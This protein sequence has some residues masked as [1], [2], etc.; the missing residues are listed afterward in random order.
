M[1]AGVLLEQDVQP[2]EQS[3]ELLC[4]HW[5]GLGV[6]LSLWDARGRCLQ[7][8]RAAAGPSKVLWDHSA[9]FRAW[10]AALCRRAVAHPADVARGQRAGLLGF[11]VPVVCCG[12]P[13]QVVVAVLVPKGFQGGDA[14][15]QL[16][17]PASLDPAIVTR[18]A[19]DVA[20]HD[21]RAVAGLEE[22]L[23]LLVEQLSRHETGTAPMQ[24]LAA[25]LAQ[26]YEV[27]NLIYH[28]SDKFE[29]RQEPD[30]FFER[31]FAEVMAVLQVESLAAVTHVSR[32][33][34][35]TVV[36][37]GKGLGQRERIHAVA[38][39]L[40]SLMLDRK[41]LLLDHASVER[42]LPQEQWLSNL[43]AV[44]LLHQG[45]PVGALLAI[46]KAAGKDFD[47]IDL[48]ML[49]VLADRCSLYL[50]DLQILADLQELLIALLRSLVS[51]IDAMDP[52]TS[53]HSE[54]VAF[55]TRKLAEHMHYDAALCQRAY[56]G[57][58]LHDIGK[59]TI[60]GRIL[61]K[62]AAL[63]AEEFDRI[64]QHPISGARLIGRIPAMQDVVPA[65][66]GHHE[67]VDGTGYPA[68]LAGDEL[69]VLARLVAVADC[70][71]AMTSRRAYRS[72][73]TIES[74]RQELASV[75]G[76]HLD[77][78]MVQA[79]LSMDLVQLHRELETY[80]SGLRETQREEMSTER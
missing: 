61:R 9:Q 62:P 10:L 46:N 58:L 65:V 70:F 49:Q 32:T 79:L 8:D 36:V 31:T 67:R 37:V 38:E 14:L 42:F 35:P 74:A 29:H 75:A 18:L 57:G 44:W 77:A 27:L 23:T 4:S 78:E 47:P 15:Q 41:M 56:F 11:A 1:S 51:T 2:L 17:E 25:N 76:T 12:V 21:P 28:V 7:T 43:V 80:H 19:G 73:K 20:W 33:G 13:E 40:S 66:I 72:G 16:C 22:M 53:G 55:V 69:P 52:Y 34:E 63:T 48:Q 26:T 6:W 39:G 30:E 68:G 24:G 54:R 59:I 71:D 64:R 60:P 45:E 5:H 50:E 3:F